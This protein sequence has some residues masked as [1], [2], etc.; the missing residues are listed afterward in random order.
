MA[1]NR[2]ARFL[3]GVLQS[4]GRARVIFGT[5]GRAQAYK[6]ASRAW[7]LRY[8]GLAVGSAVGLNCAVAHSS[9]QSERLPRDHDV[10]DRIDLFRPISFL[11][12]MV[13]DRIYKRETKKVLPPALP[14]EFGGIKYTLVLNLEGTLLQSEFMNNK[15]RTKLRPHVQ[16]F[17]RNA[18][19]LGYEVII[20]ANDDFT[21]V[22][23]LTPLLDPERKIMHHLNQEHCTF[24]RGK[25]VKDLERLNR[26]L[27]TVI[28]VDWNKE[29][30]A[31]QPENALYVKKFDGKVDYALVE[32]DALLEGIQ[33]KRCEDV[34]PVL[35]KLQEGYTLG[36]VFG[37]E[38]KKSY[39]EKLQMFEHKRRYAKI[40][41]MHKK[42]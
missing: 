13:Y 35:Q 30:W 6:F 18:Q 9:A 21:K 28:M 26:D 41:T 20:F 40:K 27:K 17:L 32:L 5:H 24:Y 29:M 19:D 23:I 8:T 3:G 15:Y 16:T 31:F 11:Y 38:V 42:G 36:E 14:D 33:K 4:V 25:Y 7:K 39:E 2:A 37:D 34:R 10:K 22:E 12:G 1:S